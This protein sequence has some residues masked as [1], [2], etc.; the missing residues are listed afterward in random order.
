MPSSKAAKASKAVH[1]DEDKQEEKGEPRKSLYDFD[2]APKE[3]LQQRRR[4]GRA[5]D[6]S[7]SDSE[8]SSSSSSE[9]DLAEEIEPSEDAAWLNV[10]MRVTNRDPALYDQAQASTNIYS[11]TM[12]ALIKWPG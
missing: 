6:Y 3:V 4:R 5:D 2:F 11:G 1:F 10:L 8:S 12:H 9:D 7:S